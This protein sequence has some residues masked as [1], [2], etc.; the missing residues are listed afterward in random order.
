MIIPKRRI[1]LKMQ[2]NTQRAIRMI[3]TTTI[4]IMNS[5]SFIVFGKRS[6]NML[7]SRLTSAPSL[8]NVSL[9]SLMESYV[10]LLVYYAKIISLFLGFCAL[11]C[12]SNLWSGDGLLFCKSLTAF[13][14]PLFY[15]FRLFAFTETSRTKNAIKTMSFIFDLIF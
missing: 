12:L 5:S 3:A 7:I 8:V 6:L 15:D 9:N 10:L 4:Q 11:I 2:H 13:C 1:Y 14:W